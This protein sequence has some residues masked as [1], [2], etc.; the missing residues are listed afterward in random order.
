MSCSYN[1]VRTWIIDELYNQAEWPLTIEQTCYGLSVGGSSAPKTFTSGE[2]DA[3]ENL[4][5]SGITS[6][7]YECDQ[8]VEDASSK[9]FLY[10]YGDQEVSCSY[11][12]VRTWII[13]ELYNQAEWPLTI[14]QACL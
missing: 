9:S 4:C 12:Q 1:Q 3:L 5:P 10:G 8:L 13:D 11:N 2:I 14:E 7:A 6:G